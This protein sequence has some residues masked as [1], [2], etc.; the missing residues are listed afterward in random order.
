MED[1]YLR[2]ARYHP[3]SKWELVFQA[4][5]AYATVVEVNDDDL[6]KLTSILRE[7]YT[8]EEGNQV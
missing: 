1:I 4:S 2:R 3:S 8:D 7:H 6:V 5:P